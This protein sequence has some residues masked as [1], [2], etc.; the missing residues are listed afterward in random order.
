ML[1]PVR[2]FGRQRLSEAGEGAALVGGHH[3]WAA[4]LAWPRLELLWSPQ[5][6]AWRDRFERE[7]A[8]L[9]AA[10]DAC[11]QAG[12]AR[13][14]LAIFTGLYGLWQTRAGSCRTSYPDAPAGDQS[15][16]QDAAAAAMAL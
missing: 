16:T 13:T 12:D 9:R 2:L 5:G 15:A 8:N 6:S 14:G 1:E 3:D 4:A 10:L 11:V 7:Q